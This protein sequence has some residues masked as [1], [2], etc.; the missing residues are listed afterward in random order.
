MGMLS[1]IF[2]GCEKPDFD[3]LV[4]ESFNGSLPPEYQE[5]YI[6]EITTDKI[7]YTTISSNKTKKKGTRMLN[8]T[9][10]NEIKKKIY[11]LKVIKCNSS[12]DCDGGGTHSLTAYKKGKK[13]FSNTHYG[14][15]DDCNG[16]Y[17]LL[18]LLNSFATTNS[19]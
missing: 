16:F 2:G 17:K 14:C 18:K 5:Q 8:K 13:V 3:E 4:Y 7:T 9:D 12:D 6:V 19:K 10:F 11:E 1:L 15:D